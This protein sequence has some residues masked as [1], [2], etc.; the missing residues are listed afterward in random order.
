M[1]A[2]PNEAVM[3]KSLNAVPGEPLLVATLALKECGSMMSGET[4]ESWSS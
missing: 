4:A 2:V 3:G 1:P